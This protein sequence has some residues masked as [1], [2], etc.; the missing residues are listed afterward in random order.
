MDVSHL[1]VPTPEMNHQLEHITQTSKTRVDPISPARLSFLEFIF[2]PTYVAF[3][4]SI[5]RRLGLFISC[6]FNSLL[7]SQHS[8][9]QLSKYIET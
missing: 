6:G 9:Y 2:T 5:V 8:N 3:L 7:F 4:N 1:N